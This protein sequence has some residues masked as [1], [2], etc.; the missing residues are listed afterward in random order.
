MS[1]KSIY[2]LPLC[3]L[4]LVLNGCSS[5]LG[6]H[7]YNDDFG[8][9]ENPKADKQLEKEELMTKE[10]LQKFKDE[11]NNTTESTPEKGTFL[12]KDWVQPAPVITYLYPYDS[13][14][15]SEDELP[16]NRGRIGN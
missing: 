16:V 9:V 6:K 5:T 7:A 10:E 13:K 1:R 3:S 12:A 4:L 8:L 15:Y 11:A 2:L 14:F